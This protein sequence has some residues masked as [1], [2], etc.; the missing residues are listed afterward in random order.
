MR[1]AVVML[2]A[3][4]LPSCLVAQ[5]TETE[6]RARLIDKPL[7]LRGQWS[8][9][10]LAFDVSGHLQGTSAPVTFTLAGVEIGLVKLTS[11]GLVLGGQ[12]VG[13]EFTKDVPK[14][15]GLVVREQT[16]DT[17]PEEITIKLQTPADGD[18]TTALDAIFTDSIA[19]L[20][21]PL[22]W[23]WRQFAQQHLLP[24]AAPVTPGGVPLPAASGGEGQPSGAAKM[25]R[26]GGGVSAPR[27]LTH[28]EPEFDGTA[29]ALKYSG[30]VLLTFVVAKDGSPSHIRILHALGLGLDERAMAA[31]A[32]YTFQPAMQNGSPVAV[33]LNVEVNFQIF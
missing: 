1:C 9:D 23:Y 8:S 22:P 10:K 6:L 5:K 20:N 28:V 15:V 29:R 3:S 30:I 27:L 24:M 2:L 12:R 31:V 21:P 25:P 26:I 7:Y 18:F 33:M 13:L 17:S 32:Q 11:K 19:G 4:T 14:R 16:G